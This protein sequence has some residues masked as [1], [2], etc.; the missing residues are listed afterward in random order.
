[1]APD[2]IAKRI[3][4]RF[5]GVSALSHALG[6]RNPTT[7]RGWLERG[8]IPARQQSA[9]LVA[10]KRA[11]IGLGANDFFDREALEA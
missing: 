7:V 8:V 3:I 4:D 6:H 2:T 9:V 1:M 5:G 10:A 11:G